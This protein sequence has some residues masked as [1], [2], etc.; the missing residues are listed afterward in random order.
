MSIFGTLFNNEETVIESYS[1]YI[2]PSLEGIMGVNSETALEFYQVNASMYIFDVVAEE[3]VIENSANPSVLLESFLK[4][5]IGKLKEIFQ[6]LAAKVRSWFEAAIKFLKRTFLSGE[7]F[8]K[9]F[10]DEIKEKSVKGFEYTGYK[11]TLEK[12]EEHSREVLST[13]RR[14]LDE[15][16]KVA[17]TV[18]DNLEKLD[19]EV[20]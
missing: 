7:K 20:D 10:Q 1:G 19:I 12:G 18:F 15:K 3:A 5:K 17:E 6:K 2:E 8:V 4:D 14:F 16:V 11:I 13:L 9:E